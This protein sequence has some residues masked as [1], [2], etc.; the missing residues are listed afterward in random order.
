MVEHRKSVFQQLRLLGLGVVLK[1]LLRR[2]RM[3]D[4]LQLL[5]RLLELRGQTVIL[6][7]AEAGMDVDKPQQLEQVLAYLRQHPRPSSHQNQPS[8]HA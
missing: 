3:D 8:I 1:F 4:L 7:F 6:P 2:L 5:Q